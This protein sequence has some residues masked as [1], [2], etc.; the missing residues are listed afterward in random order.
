MFKELTAIGKAFYAVAK[1]VYEHLK[2]ADIERQQLALLTVQYCFAGLSDTGRQLL[3]LA[4]PKPLE[5]V[6]SLSAAELRDFSAQVQRHLSIQQARLHKLNNILQDQQ[7]IELFDMSL[8]R[9]ISEAIGD[10]EDG[11]YAIGAAL[12]FYFILTGPPPGS[13]DPRDFERTAYLI[14]SMYPEIESGVI[15]IPDAVGLLDELNALAQRY[16][17]LLKQIVPAERFLPLSREA[18]KLANVEA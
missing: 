2:C 3:E 15:S 18:A 4:G 13:S 11:L 6:A 7:V 16:G 5:K 17:E 8:R 10:K 1:A 12:M 9:E 14:S